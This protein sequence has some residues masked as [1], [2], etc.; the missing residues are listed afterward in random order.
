[1]YRSRVL[2]PSV[3]C[4]V[5]SL[6]SRQL[7]AGA[8]W[9]A[10]EIATGQDKAVANYPKITGAGTTIAVLDTGVDY[11]HPALG[12]GWG[13]KVVAGYDFVDNDTDPMDTV[14]HGTGIAA[15]AAGL[16]YTYKGAK[17]QGVA[18]GAKVVALRVDNEKLKWG[19]M[20]ANTERALQWVIAN[21]AKYHIVAVNMSYGQ[22]HFGTDDVKTGLS[23]ELAKLRG[24]GILA[25]SSSGNDGLTQPNGIEYP[26]ADANVYAAGAANVDGSIWNKTERGKNLDLLAPGS[27]ITLP[28]YD[29]ATH[30]HIYIKGGLGSSWAAPWVSGTAALLQQLK[31]G[32]TPAQSMSAMK[33]GGVTKSDST[34]SWKLL[35]INGALAAAAGQSTGGGSTGGGSTGGGGNTGGGGTTSAPA[36]KGSSNGIAYDALGNL[37]M[38]WYDESSHNLKYA[39]RAANGT[40]GGTT[41]IDGGSMA[42]QFV[43]LAVDESNRPGVAYYDAN[44]GDLKYAHFN[45]SSWDV[46]RVDSANTVGYYPSLRYG[47]F[48]V[49]FISYYYKTG[50]DLRIAGLGD[51]GWEIGAIE[52]AGDVGRYSSLALNPATGRWSVAYEDTSHGWF[53]YANETR[54]GW[55]P[56]VVDNGTKIGGGYVSLAFNPKTH[57]PAM[58]YY[59]A[60]NGDLKYAQ[61]SGSKWSRQTVAAKGTVGLYSNL[62]IEGSGAADILYYSKNNDAVFRAHAASSSWALDE[63]TGGGGR[64]ISRAGDQTM[65]YV[66]SAGGLAIAAV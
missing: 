64:W 61:S 37:H 43:S 48:S 6:E 34:G 16:P 4:T 63:V 38:A 33:A 27:G 55:A 51:G 47:A 9:G 66:R 31:P 65:A 28:Y 52:T 19:Q 13:K 15:L 29:A 45:G 59:D 62:L 2:H 44:N 7:L 25:V 3:P 26:A 35:N 24:M 20:A 1:M 46:Q 53:K 18:P 40:W 8:P 41:T 56:T 32:L 23:D 17:F 22:G 50:G 30:G 11:N 36:T 49:P 54:R 42:G 57:L 14:G 60:Y 39:R 10:Q 58:S 21:A 12:G 5:E